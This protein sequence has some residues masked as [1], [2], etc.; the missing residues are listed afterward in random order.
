VC[1]PAGSAVTYFNASGSNSSATI[2]SAGLARRISTNE[3]DDL[4]MV[5][6]LQFNSP[7]Q[8]VIATI[9]NSGSITGSYSA[10]FTASSVPEP[11]PLALSLV[12]LSLIGLRIFGSRK[13]K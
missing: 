4:K 2:S 6:S 9:N 11:G 10:T 12:G 5:F 13:T 8:S 3:F 1:T 7:F